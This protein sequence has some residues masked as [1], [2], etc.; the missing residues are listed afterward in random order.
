MK[1]LVWGAS[2]W[3]GGM[4]CQLLRE[5]GHEV[6]AAKSRTRDH[7][8]MSQ[9]L[10][11]VNPDRVLNVAGIT[12][13]PSVDWC[14]DHQQETYLVNAVGTANLADACWE[15][16][17]HVTY[18]ATGCIYTYDDTHP[19]GSTFSE[20]DPPNFKGSTYSK[21]KILAEELLVPYPNVL[22]LRIRMPISAD[23]HPKNIITK[24]SKYAKVINIP[25]SFTSLPEMLPISIKMSLDQVTGIYNFTNPGAITHQD[26]LNLYKKYLNPDHTWETFTEEEQNAILRSKR[27]NCNLD[28]TKL[29]KYHP[30]TPI[31]IAIEQIFMTIASL[32]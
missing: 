5:Q 29:E 24:L 12:G 14:E 7:V 16:G 17:I 20:L 15:K 28:T 30:V 23:L 10:E 25:N 3:I 22:T 1:F 11:L 32:K 2:G 19:V 18:Y 8:G 26:I 13:K 27:S 4:L 9:E 6:I 21:S 31:A